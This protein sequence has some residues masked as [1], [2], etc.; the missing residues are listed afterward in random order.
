MRYGRYTNIKGHR[1]EFAIDLIVP[2]NL[3]TPREA[4][5]QKAQ[6][7]SEHKHGTRKGVKT[8]I[9]RKTT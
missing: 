3:F 6:L 8:P 1:E 5:S 7:Q 2:H 4:K 9:K